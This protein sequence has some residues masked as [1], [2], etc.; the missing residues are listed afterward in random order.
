[1][2]SD[3]IMKFSI[4]AKIW[5][6]VHVMFWVWVQGR[7]QAWVWANVGLVFGLMFDFH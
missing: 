5:A 1:M 2:E 3:S 7:A 6:R 4:Q